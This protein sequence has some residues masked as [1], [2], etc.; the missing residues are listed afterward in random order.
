MPSTTQESA[1]LVSEHL[2]IRPVTLTRS[3]ISRVMQILHR[4]APIFSD[5]AE[6][7]WGLEVWIVEQGPEIHPHIRG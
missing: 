1:K 6:R 4:T 3:W 7:L 2:Q 5:V